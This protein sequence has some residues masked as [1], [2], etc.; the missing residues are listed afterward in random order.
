MRGARSTMGAGVDTRARGLI[1]HAPHGM[2]FDCAL[3]HYETRRGTS[4]LA[5]DFESFLPS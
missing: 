5:N 4:D 1:R 2:S 3:L